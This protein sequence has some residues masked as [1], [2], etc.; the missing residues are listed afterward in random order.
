MSWEC[1]HVPTLPELSVDKMAHEFTGRV[2]RLVASLLALQTAFE[3]F[4]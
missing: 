2:G 4:E 3:S 1:A